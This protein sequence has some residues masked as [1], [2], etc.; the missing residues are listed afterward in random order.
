MMERPE[1]TNQ[2]RLFDPT[3]SAEER[4]LEESLRAVRPAPLSPGLRA[5][6]RGLSARAVQVPGRFDR[7]AKLAL[8]WACAACL[9][10][11]FLVGQEARTSAPAETTTD[12][13]SRT[14]VSVSDE[15][16]DLGAAWRAVELE[17]DTSGATRAGRGEAELP[18]LQNPYL[19]I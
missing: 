10:L 11:G 12:T 2:D 8:P 17:S 14:L 19:S 3:L 1:E 15:M 13:L 4:A 16:G 5:E 6:L 9:A 18:R 7:A